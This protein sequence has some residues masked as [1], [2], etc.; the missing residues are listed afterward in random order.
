MAR[1]PTTVV[2]DLG[3][4]LIDWNPRHLYRKLFE[5]EEE[6]ERFLAEVCT[7]DWNGE[8]DRGRPFA[9]AA[10]LLIDR[11]PGQAAM[12]EAFFARWPEMLNGPIQ[13]T[14]AVLEELHAAGVPLF[15]LTNWSAETWPLARPLFPFLDRFRGILV[16]GQVGLIKPDAAIFRRLCL[17]FALDPE[18]SVFIDDSPRNVEAAEALGFHAHHFRGPE[19][20]RGWLAGHGL[21]PER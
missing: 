3:G 21:P 18:D 7:G 6:M 5:R 15:A 4:V 16:S 9:E 17:D 10:R 12:V 11:H 13:G 8:Q 14:V 19:A 2:F 20:L 1:S